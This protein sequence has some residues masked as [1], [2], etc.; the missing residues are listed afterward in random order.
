MGVKLVVV[1]SKAKAAKIQELLGGAYRVEPSMGHVRDLPNVSGNSMGI[2]VK[3]GFKP[4]YTASK[5]DIVTKLR[6]LLA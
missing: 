1:E 4:A 5:R 3:N 2:D 6:G